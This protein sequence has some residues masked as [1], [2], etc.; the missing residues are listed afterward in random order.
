[1]DLVIDI[2]IAALL[3]ILKNKKQIQMWLPALA[4]VAVALERTAELVPDLAAAIEKKRME[5]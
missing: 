4:K 3:R 2:G 5:G 1:M